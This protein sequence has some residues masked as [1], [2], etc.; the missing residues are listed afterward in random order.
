MS[1][2][3]QVTSHPSWTAFLI[4]MIILSMGIGGAFFGGYQMGKVKGALVAIKQNPPNTYSGDHQLVT[5]D[6]SSKKVGWW[7]GL[8]I[9]PHSGIGF[10]HD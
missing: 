6:Q 8:R 7:V 5:V 3:I 2:Q 4:Y 10:C 1:D 9:M